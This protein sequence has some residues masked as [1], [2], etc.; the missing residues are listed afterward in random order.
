M[1]LVTFVSEHAYVAVLPVNNEN[2][3]WHEFKFRLKYGINC[4]CRKRWGDVAWTQVDNTYDG[5]AGQNCQG[6]KVTV[7]SNDNTALHNCAAKQLH[8][9]G[10]EEPFFGNIKYVQSALSKP[11]NDVTM[12]ALIGK[13]LEVAKLQ[14]LTSASVSTSFLTACAA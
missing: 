13:E 2:K 10:A 11:L 3:R 8:V 7:V 5:L 9:A 1:E 14:D 12:N 4:L 6:A